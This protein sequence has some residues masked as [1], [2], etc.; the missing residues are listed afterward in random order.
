M[1]FN[2][3]NPIK[4]KL[5]D[6]GREIIK[7]RHEDFWSQRNADIEFKPW[8]EDEDGWSK[9]QMYNVFHV[10]GDY[11]TVGREPP[12]ETEIDLMIEERL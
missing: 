1:K 7:K 9:Q 12:F 4:I 3:N 6:K 10:F 11:L 5:T 8:P 2:I